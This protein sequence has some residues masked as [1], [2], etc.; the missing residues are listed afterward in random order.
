[1][2]LHFT[3]DILYF[4]RGVS[5]DNAKS[6]ASNT[7]SSEENITQLDDIR[8]K[9]DAEKKDVAFLGIHR[10]S[11]TNKERCAIYKQCVDLDIVVAGQNA[12]RESWQ[13]DNELRKYNFYNIS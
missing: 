2:E 6:N 1:M 3:L 4:I 7:E 8:R 11:M 10:Y 12:Q 9:Q 13:K 5:T